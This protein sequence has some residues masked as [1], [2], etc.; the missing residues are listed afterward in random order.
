MIENS[1]YVW[2]CIHILNKRNKAIGKETE[3]DCVYNSIIFT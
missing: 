1:S 3:V 2:L